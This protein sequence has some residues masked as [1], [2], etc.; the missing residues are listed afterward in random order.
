[1]AAGETNI[2]GIV[3]FLRLEAGQF[4]REIQQALLE[5]EALDDKDVRVSV[6]TDGK[7][8]GVEGLDQLERKAK[9]ASSSL[10]D[11][12]RSQRRLEDATN[13]VNL[14]Q[15]RLSELN[16]SGKAKASQLMAAE[17]AL[18]K[19][20]RD[21]QD[22]IDATYDSNRNL[23]RSN[24]DLVHS[25]K[26]VE[27]SN[28]RV[29]KSAE[30]SRRGAGALLTAIVALGPALV[31]LAA[32]AAGLAVG[33]GGMAT[34]GILAVVGIKNEMKAGT[35]V[36]RAYGVALGQAKDDL[37]QLGAVAARNVLAP[38]QTA[39]ADLTA[40]TPALS[41]Q[42]GEMATITGK[43]AVN[44]T[45]GLLSAFEALRPVMLD[46]ATYVLRLSQRFSDAMQ[47]PGIVSFGDYVRS[48]FPQVVQSIEDIAGA[49]VKLV[50][51]FAPLGMGT[52]TAIGNIAAA[53]GAIPADK[54]QV[55]AT[56]ASSVFLGFQTW[57][58]LSTVITKV[59]NAVSDVATRSVRAAAAV[60]GLQVAA[61]VIGIALAGLSL[62]LANTA[63]STRENQEAVNDWADALR[64][65]NGALDE[66]IR[67][68][69][70]MQLVDN[71]AADAGKRFG[72][73]LGDLT[74]AAL[75]LPGAMDRVNT[76]ID[77][78]GDKLKTVA[79]SGR[80]AAVVN[81]DLG[82]AAVDLKDKLGQTNGQLDA[83]A[84]AYADIK[85]AAEGATGSVSFSAA[86]IQNLADTYG[87]NATTFM[88][89]ATAQQHMS[90]K[91]AAA[92][93]QMQLQ[94]DAAGLLKQSLDELNGEK[95]SAEEADIAFG[96]AQ[97]QV[98]AGI[99]AAKEREAQ[100]LAAMSSGG[101]SGGTSRSATDSLARARLAQSQA[102][103]HLARLQSDP[104][105]TASSLESAR[106]RLANA[107]LRL[108]QAEA[109]VASSTTKSTS[110]ATAAE[111]AAYA[112]A[113]ADAA[114][115]TSLT[116][117]SE[118]ALTNRDNLLQAIK[119]AEAK[120]GVDGNLADASEAARKKLSQLKDEIIKNAVA[121]GL[122]KDEV[123]KYVNELLKIPTKLPPTQAELDIAKAL[124]QKKALQ[125]AINGI[126]G[127]T[128][129]LTIQQVYKTIGS[130]A[131]L[132][133][134]NEQTLA[135]HG[136]NPN[137]RTGGPIP[138]YAVGTLVGPGTGTSDS[139]LAMV[140]QTG[141]MLR[142]SAGEFVSTD[143]SRQRN[144]AALEAGNRGATLTVAG[145]IP[146]GNSVA[147]R[148]NHGQLVSAAAHRRNEERR[149]ARAATNRLHPEDI[150][151][152]GKEMALAIRELPRPRVDVNDFD[153]RL[154]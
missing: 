63:E 1:M 133:V 64:A 153:R 146:K 143:A 13:R 140:A 44:I 31:P 78:Q 60:R 101:S 151:A 147:L 75:G 42:L 132:Q 79:S 6:R 85:A 103:A 29:G 55:I 67:R 128:V 134:H 148:L 16:E 53:I 83:G 19:A 65:S 52:L 116:G 7:V 61:G 5:I 15:M 142:V 2:G 54:L 107:N 8:G 125:D 154:A 105:S 80:Y 113:K 120:A 23:D 20:R 118:A 70:A 98:G 51:A 34:A 81:S 73:T 109:K 11:L 22:A 57:S 77:A 82:N 95:Q 24:R 50:D 37:N 25:N 10:D 110:A 39:V 86:A 76:A 92:T 137:L 136:I 27:E 117:N 12:G 141:R 74:D 30:E 18:A 122:N 69:A 87:V 106:N 14:A 68:K 72:L 139:I 3:G 28:R 45:T 138:G 56:L 84:K 40:R 130:Q 59:A 88:N 123:T 94:N 33:F 4:H 71:G 41:D 100:A 26:D 102:A 119:A 124:K 115:A 48:V 43:V 38:L 149:E 111:K 90:D 89:A 131:A 145:G 21:E 47:G 91:L 58:G 144:Q 129:T 114:A 150:R 152:I 104:K 35:D 99:R 9:S 46:V 121:Q 66:S 49:A 135:R 126:T 93:I 108:Q 62:L 36:G 32:G 17:Q 97:N 127:K 112:Q 96:R